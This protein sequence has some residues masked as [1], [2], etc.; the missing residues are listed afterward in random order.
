[1]TKTSPLDPSDTFLHRHIGPNEREVSDMLEALGYQSLDD[2]VSDTI[3]PAILME[4]SLE[5]GPPRG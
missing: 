5:I 4:G 2:L 1:M 3:P